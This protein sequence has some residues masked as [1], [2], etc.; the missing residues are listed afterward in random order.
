MRGK[1][2]KELYIFS[3]KIFALGKT[4]NSLCKF[5]ILINF[6]LSKTLSVVFSKIELELL[7]SV[8]FL[9]PKVN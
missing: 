4:E 6:E 8:L 7:I 2:G 3:E 5:E 9:L 1:L